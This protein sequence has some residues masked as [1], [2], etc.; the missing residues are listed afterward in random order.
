MNRLSL[1]LTVSLIILIALL[2]NSIF[3]GNNSYQKKSDLIVEND[4]QI[5]KNENDI[6]E[7]EIKNAQQ[8]NE[9]VEN[10]AREKLNLVYPEEEFISFK[11]KESNKDEK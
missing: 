9:H 11:D 8:S 1:F 6:L 4:I 2:L 10:F 3:F 7:F 5:Q